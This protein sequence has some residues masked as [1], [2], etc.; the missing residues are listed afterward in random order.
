MTEKQLRKKLKKL[1]RR[2]DVLWDFAVETRRLIDPEW[3]KHPLCDLI[4]TMRTTVAQIPYGSS[5]V[6]WF[7]E[8]DSP[9][10]MGVVATVP[11]RPSSSGGSA[12]VTVGLE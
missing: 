1:Q 4:P 11:V 7:S 5:S 3:G 10:D 6:T 12:L 9:P 2:Y 8:N